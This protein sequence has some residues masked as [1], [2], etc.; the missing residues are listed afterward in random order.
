MRFYNYKN[1]KTNLS[2]A[3]ASAPWINA[4]DI[5]G[6]GPKGNR[7]CVGIVELV[8]D[9]PTKKLIA[10]DEAGNLLTWNM[11]WALKKLRM[12]EF[13]HEKFCDSESNSK[14]RKAQKLGDVM[15]PLEA[16]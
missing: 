8:W 2:S 10:G 4:T 13:S 12:I 6:T 15:H 3:L 11:R 16:Q 7:E 1:Q 14:L 5:D 9:Y